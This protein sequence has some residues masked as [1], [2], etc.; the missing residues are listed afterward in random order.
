MLELVVLDDSFVVT[1]KKMPFVTAMLFT[2]IFVIQRY[3]IIASLWQ[4]IGAGNNIEKNGGEK[5]V[6][7]NRVGKGKVAV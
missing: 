2:V 1:V 3:S 5:H 6:L 4:D 7:R